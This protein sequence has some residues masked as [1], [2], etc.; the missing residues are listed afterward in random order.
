LHVF[1]VVANADLP[2]IFVFF[3]CKPLLEGGSMALHRDIYWVGRQWAVTGF[4]VQAIDQRLQ[5][6]FD[7]ESS[8]VWDEGLQV[9]MRKHAWVNGED[10]DKA[11]MVA[12]QRFPVPAAKS[13]PLVE[14]VL[15]LIQQPVPGPAQQPT[16]P[17][18]DDQADLQR[19]E[20]SARVER[21]QAAAPLL[22]LRT[23]GRLA[24]FLPQWRVK[25]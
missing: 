11:L 2:V 18:R 23:Q 10:F 3:L 12:R 17:P 21:P 9:R 14:S 1:V 6:A 25:R 15:E 16:P 5:G 7:V 24:R 4:G 13:L 20:T 22:Q 19:A 8:Q